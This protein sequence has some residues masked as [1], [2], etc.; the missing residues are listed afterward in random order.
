MTLFRN[1]FGKKRAQQSAPSDS[2]QLEQWLQEFLAIG[3]YVEIKRM[4]E[5]RPELLGD[6][7]IALMEKS[8]PLQHNQQ[9]LE[10]LN[11]HLK[12]LRSCREH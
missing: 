9:V 11:D 10:T 5:L 1:L 2:H 7:A 12:I 3:S 4:L 6:E 8:I